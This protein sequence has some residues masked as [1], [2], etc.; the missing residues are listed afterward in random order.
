[1]WSEKSR[2]DGFSLEILYFDGIPTMHQKNIMQ[3]KIN[4]AISEL[5]KH[6]KD[7]P[8]YGVNIDDMYAYNGVKR[9]DFY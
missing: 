1:L 8:N 5:D 6:F 3:Q 4:D 2:K 9:S 7:E